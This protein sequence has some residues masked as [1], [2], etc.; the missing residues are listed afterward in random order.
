MNKQW[1]VKL[2]FNTDDAVEDGQVQRYAKE[3]AEN[4]LNDPRGSEYNQ[5]TSEGDATHPCTVGDLQVWVNDF[6]MCGVCEAF[7]DDLPGHQCI[8]CYAFKDL[9]N[10]FVSQSDA[11]A[12]AMRL[13]RVYAGPVNGVTPKSRLMVVVEGPGEQQW[14]V[15]EVRDAIEEDFKWEWA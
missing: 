10:T 8:G 9:H 14:T 6:E 3:L 2:T 13:N 15:M 11:F 4:L 1:E 5:I 7:T 12:E